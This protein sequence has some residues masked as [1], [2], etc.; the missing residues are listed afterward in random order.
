M[1]DVVLVTGGA[2]Y[3]GS[4]VA[5]AFIDAGWSVIVVDDLSTGHEPLIPREAFFI[6]GHVGDIELMRSVLKEFKPDAVVHLAG[7][8]VVPESVKNPTLYYRNNTLSSLNLIDSCVS[9]SIKTFIFSSTAAVYG[10]A[11]FAREDQ[12]T[13]P[14]NPYGRSKL[15]VEQM[16]KDISLAYGLNYGV[17]RYFNVAGADPMMRTGQLSKIATHLVKIAIE[18]AVGKR[19]KVVVYGKDYPTKDGTAI[20]DY[21]HVSDLAD[22]HVKTVEHVRKTKKNATFN[23]GYGRGESVLDVLQKII[24]VTKKDIAIHF[25]SRREGDPPV[26]IAGDRHI[27]QT[28]N[29]TPKHNLESIVK[30]AFDWEMLCKQ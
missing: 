5:H 27:K 19:E 2:G 26:L 22:I 21:I 29:W 14:M 24:E 20:R 7:S 10:D 12:T 23:C 17:L 9:H 11:V 1:Q 18:A 13:D 16:L 30:T 28:L 15:M 8:I 6:K 3:I 25:G 4:H